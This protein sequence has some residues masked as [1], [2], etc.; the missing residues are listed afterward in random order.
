MERQK[1][2]LEGSERSVAHGWLRFNRGTLALK[3]EALDDER[4]RSR[5]IQGSSNSLL[6]LVRHMTNMELTRIRWFEEP[7]AHLVYPGE[8]DFDGVDD[9][10]VAIVL[11]RWRAECA[12]SDRII[13]AH[14]TDEASATWRSLRVA[15]QSLNYEYARHCGHADVLRELLDG[16]TGF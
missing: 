8:D 4:L 15:M 5:P 6:G 11:E 16:R 9:L 7:A 14:E 2:P 3:I 10:D 13:D 12:N 1:P